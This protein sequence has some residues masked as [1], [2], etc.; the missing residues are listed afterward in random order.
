MN[1]NLK[2]GALLFALAI[3]LIASILISLFLSLDLGYTKL[4]RKFT[5]YQQGVNKLDEGVKLGY[6]LDSEKY[7][8]KQEE[9]T[10]NLIVNKKLWGCYFLVSTEVKLG[11]TSS[12]SKAGLIG[13]QLKKDYCLYL[14][15]RN[16][17]LSLS[18]N[19]LLEGNCFLPEKGVGIS[20]VEGK[21]YLR[22][23]LVNGE[24]MKS[25]SRLPEINSFLIQQNL[26]SLQGV[27]NPT[28]DSIIPLNELITTELNQSF[29]NKTLVI[30]ANS[31]LVLDASWSLI[32]NVI[33]HSNSTITVKSGAKLDN[34]ILSAE[35][36]HLQKDV[37]ACAQLIGKNV[38]TLDSNSHLTYPSSVLSI[39]D[40]STIQL[41]GNA[42]INGSLISYSQLSNSF[43]AISLSKNSQVTG[44]VY[45]TN[46][47]ELKG[48]IKGKLITQKL[49]YRSP[50]TEY[51]NT[52]IDAEINNSILPDFYSCAPLLDEKFPQINVIKWL[53]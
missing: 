52:L 15:D 17:Q 51:T 32:G 50:S 4:T 11:S 29:F 13:N 21:S 37:Q 33:V 48:K 28:Q 1:I 19:T 3:L 7:E 12:L 36:I 14:A 35:N 47:T 16:T 2:G 24:V 10:H 41:L 27:F 49:F 44:L 9:N 18:G 25:K 23:K 43:N 39:G 53:K 45:C 40:S 30:F 26:L 31:S 8:G 46:R 38:I 34:V 5:E 20:Y 42:S 22:K 6:Y